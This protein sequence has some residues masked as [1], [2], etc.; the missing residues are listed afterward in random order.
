MFMD[1][2]SP[3]CKILTP[4]GDIGKAQRRRVQVFFMKEAR[5]WTSLLVSSSDCYLSNS[6]KISTN[7]DVVYPSLNKIAVS[8]FT[9]N[10]KGDGRPFC[11]VL[12]F[13]IVRLFSKEDKK[14]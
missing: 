9:N 5:T 1:I 6:T 14:V 2:L 11:R 8:L 4:T 13:L 7:T 10:E 3:P 12:A